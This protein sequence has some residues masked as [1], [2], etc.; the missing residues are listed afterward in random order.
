MKKR[1]ENLTVVENRRLNNEFFVLTLKSQD[2]I[3]DIL[4]GQF[5][6]V[7]VDDS[8]TTFLRRPFSVYD[9]DYSENTLDLLIKIAGNG[10]AKMSF[11]RQGDIVNL[12][13]P[14]GNSFSR[15]EG[16]NVLLV[17]G[18]TGVAP[19]LLLGKYLIKQWDIN[20]RFLLGYRSNDLIVEKQ[21]F[22]SIGEVYFTTDNGSEGQKGFVTKHSLL[23]KDIAQFDRLYAC[24]PEVMMKAIARIACEKNIPCEVSLENLMGCGFGACLCCIAD[25]TDKGNVNTCTEGPVFNVQRLKWQI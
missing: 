15:P 17:G 8:P 7:R 14:L 16:P 6:E 10:T 25:T 20:P 1:V 23:G 5:A 9:V 3:P 11:L 24:G 13:Y 2:G 22:E 19:L 18:G 21:R 4:P 12:I